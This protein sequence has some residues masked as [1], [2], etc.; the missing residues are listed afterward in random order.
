MYDKFGNKLQTMAQVRDIL[1]SEPAQ[2]KSIAKV[3]RDIHKKREYY[4]NEVLMEHPEENIY[5][6]DDIM[7]K[8]YYYTKLAQRLGFSK[9]Y[10]FNPDDDSLREYDLEEKELKNKGHRLEIKDSNLN[11]EMINFAKLDHAVEGQSKKR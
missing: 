6:P 5:H 1:R 3:E 9:A 4:P 2:K 10:D 7:D 8:D 11:A